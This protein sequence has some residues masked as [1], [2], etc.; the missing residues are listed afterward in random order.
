[1]SRWFGVKKTKQLWQKF[2]FLSKNGAGKLKDFLRVLKLSRNFVCILKAQVSG[3]F[4]K[5]FA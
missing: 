2:A 4:A 3:I 1:L 5:R